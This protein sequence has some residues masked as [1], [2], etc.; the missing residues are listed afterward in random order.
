[1]FTGI[2]PRSPTP[3]YQQLA[4]SV[5]RSVTSGE[6]APGDPLPTRALSIARAVRGIKRDGDPGHGFALR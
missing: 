4:E 2:N 1:M 5:R 3:L 6:L